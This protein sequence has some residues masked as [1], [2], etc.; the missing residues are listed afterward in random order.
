MLFTSATKHAILVW[1]I[2]TTDHVCN[3]KSEQNNFYYT[4][5][6]FLAFIKHNCQQIQTVVP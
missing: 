4:C 6:L 1:T 5:V 3:S 2:K